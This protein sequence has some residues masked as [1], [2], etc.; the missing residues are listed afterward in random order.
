ML[1]QFSKLRQFNWTDEQILQ[2]GPFV[3]ELQN[4]LS[5]QNEYLKNVQEKI[6]ESTDILLSGGSIDS[7]DPQIQEDVIAKIQAMSEN[8]VRAMGVF[9]AIRFAQQL[10]AQQEQLDSQALQLQNQA[11]MQKQI[12]TVQQQLDATNKQILQTLCE[13]KVSTETLNKTAEEAKNA[14]TAAQA[15]LPD[16]LKNIFSSQ[17]N[18]K[19]SYQYYEEE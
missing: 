14:A 4:A 5:Q 7:I 10:T 15:I 11:V 2:V 9:L 13:I 8:D 19:N 18:T 3:E 6:D 16:W 12:V 17:K 1:E